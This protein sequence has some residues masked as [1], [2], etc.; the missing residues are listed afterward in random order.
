MDVLAAIKS[1][2]IKR[3]HREE[4]SAA[5]K[6]EALVAEVADERITG[7]KR[8]AEHV[9]KVLDECEQTIVDLERPVGQRKRRRSLE[10][11]AASCSEREEEQ[12]RKYAEWE[13]AR[14]DHNRMVREGGEKVNRLH[15]D[16]EAAAELTNGAVQAEQ[17]L[18]KSFPESEVAL[19]VRARAAARAKEDRLHALRAKLSVAERAVQQISLAIKIPKTF[20]GNPVAESL[21][22]LEGRKDLLARLPQMR[23]LLEK[24]RTCQKNRDAIAGELA[25]AEKVCAKVA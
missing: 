22:A 24:W 16:F 9:E 2:I 7:S 20:A 12:R 18:S 8:S 6:W 1:R 14:E 10:A 11:L 13:Q 19:R 25:A 17:E 4:Q 15:R 23:K 5:E 3:K 21:E